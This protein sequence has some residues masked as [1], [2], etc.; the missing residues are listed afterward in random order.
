MTTMPTTVQERIPLTPVSAPP[1]AGAITPGDV[2]GM[3]KRRIV[4]ICVLSVLFGGIGVGLFFLAYFKFPKYSAEAFIECISDRPEAPLEIQQ[5]Q[6]AQDAFTRFVESQAL[7]M[8]SYVVL[9]GVL[10]NPE[11]RSTSWFQQTPESDR[12]SELDG[13]LRCAPIP[14]TNYVRVAIA[15]KS[16]ADP[17]KIVNALVD[18]YLNEVRERASA[19][20]RSEVAEYKRELGDI[21]AQ[22]QKKQGQIA[23]F[24]GQ[25]PA[26]E[27]R[28]E[29]GAGVLIEQLRKDQETV[30][31]LEQQTAELEG[32]RNLYNDPEGPAVTAEVRLQVES[33]PR[34]AQLTNQIFALQQELNILYKRFG[35]NH[36]ESKELLTRLEEAEH[37]VEVIRQNS[38]REILEH[39]KEQIES[40]FVNSQHAL[41][42]AR[43]RLQQTQANQADVDQKLTQYELLNDELDLLV[44]IQKRLDE[45]I[46]E[47]ERIVRE[48]S[49]VRVSDAVRATPPL[50]RSFPSL[51][52][53]PMAVMGAL[54]LSV[55]LA[56]GLELIDTSVKTSQ[57]VVRH[58]H[59][60]MLGSIPDVDDEEVEIDPVETAVIDAPQSMVTEAFRTVRSNLQFSAPADRMR[61]ILI[62]SP[63][64]ED[65]KTTVAANLAASLANAGRRVLLV[66]ANLRRPSLHRVFPQIGQRGMTNVL[67]GEARWEEL[68]VSTNLPNLD[69]I[70]AG[71]I[72]P[73]PAELLG[74]RL[75]QE[76]LNE[77]TA[78]YD[79]VVIDSP[80]VLLASDA[81]V[82]ATA[83]DGTILVCRAKSNSRGVAQ[84]ACSLL[85]HV[86]AHVFGVVLNVA[87][88]RRG[89]YFREQFRTFYEYQYEEDD[90]DR[91][92]TRPAL[93]ED[94]APAVSASDDDDDERDED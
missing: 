78:K 49:A 27:S 32:L 45:Y 34:V 68:A 92:R 47:I 59:L 50:Q 16:P 62:T 40:A 8:K 22:I 70:G 61:S 13:A 3:L 58:L 2:I 14:K 60:A 46:R 11:V 25:L 87:Q 83:T 41:L 38:L 85:Y 79:H 20:Y 67:I 18:I 75:F 63:K 57:D 6:L 93:P 4:T 24:V 54:G 94:D 81:S 66:D 84:R 28:N 37:Q 43:E 35:P 91:K 39:Q 44:E 7:F 76:F 5:Y 19:A 23:D 77:A 1:A 30:A 26:G 29:P 33:D 72:P 86:N 82:L 80:P 10:K 15:T 9:S 56:I 55:G 51:F 21:Q 52:L 71:P 90:N 89:G 88:A 64:P 53:L 48:R 17:H 42:L 31:T 69:L 65:G 36:R 73:N 74:S 12:L